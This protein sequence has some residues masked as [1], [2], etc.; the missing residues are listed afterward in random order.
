M[1]TMLGLAHLAEVGFYREVRV[2][3]AAW[4]GGPFALLGPFGLA[5]SGV[6]TQI[7]LS[8]A[9]RMNTSH[10][11]HHYTART[12]EAFNTSIAAWTSV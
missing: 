10:S 8:S 9:M 1:R 2:I 6:N 11:A 12:C 3:R 7:G 4:T 5:A